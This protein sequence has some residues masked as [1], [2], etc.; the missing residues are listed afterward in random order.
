[1][2]MTTNEWMNILVILIGSCF[3][4]S[5]FSYLD[6]RMKTIKSRYPELDELAEQA[7]NP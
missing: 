3:I 5:G 7:S 2:G 1:M 6:W 4:L